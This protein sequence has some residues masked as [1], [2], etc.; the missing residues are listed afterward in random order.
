[1]AVYANANGVAT[2]KFKIPAGIKAGTKRVE[3]KGVGG[4]KSHAE[5]TFTGQGTVVTN[6]MRQVKNVM[7][8]Y[9]DPLAQTFM[10]NEARQLH[11]MDVWVMT[12]GTTPLIVQ[13]RET[14]TGFPTRTVLAEG[15]IN[16]QTTIS[17]NGWTSIPFDVP[18]YAE[19]NV[20]YAV[21]V[22]AN[23]SVTEVAISELGKIDPATNSYVTTQPYQVGV[24]LSS[25]NASTWTA[26]QDK[27]LTFRLRARKYDKTKVK[28]VPLGTITLPADTTDLLISALTNTPSTGADAEIQLISTDPNDPTQKLTRTVSDGQVIK[29]NSVT[30]GDVEVVAVLRCTD[31]ASATIS[32]GSQFIAGKMAMTGTY[33]S[34]AIPANPNA[35]SILTVTFE[36]QN[37][38]TVK[39]EY[40]EDKQDGSALTGWVELVR[41]PASSTASSMTSGRAE[42]TFKMPESPPGTPGSIPAMKFLKVRI[43]LGGTA[44]SR[45]EVFNLRVSVTKV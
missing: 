15:R 23:D 30:S 13:L 42:M 35:K 19:A 1:M 3:F 28:T 33:V 4:S 41:P 32:P 2:G 16:D 8:A 20:E 43:T 6:T 17:T 21:V 36:Q 7:Q 12:K 22:L 38:S 14:S 44:S 37:V 29:F 31:T 34:G 27:D 39:V 9:Y 25:A 11:G 10:L 45:P 5:T 24:L 40:A 26:H 18:Y